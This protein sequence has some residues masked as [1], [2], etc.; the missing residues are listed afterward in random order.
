MAT[1]SVEQAKKLLNRQDIP[2]E[3]FESTSEDTGK[4]KYENLAS[5]YGKNDD[6]IRTEEVIKMRKANGPKVIS[7]EEFEELVDEG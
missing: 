4:T 2:D 5:R 6:I 3:Y 1:I 7:P